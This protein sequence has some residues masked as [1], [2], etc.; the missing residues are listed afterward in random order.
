MPKSK[1]KLPLIFTT[2]RSQVPCELQ[3]LLRQ[4]ASSR[5]VTEGAIDASIL[6]DAHQTVS[7]LLTHLPS[8]GQALSQMRKVLKRQEYSAECVKNA[9]H[10][11]SIR[12]LGDAELYLDDSFAVSRECHLDVEV[13]FDSLFASTDS[14]HVDIQLGP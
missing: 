6:D 2:T 5:V 7:R 13:D 11:S 12:S 8:H 14:S 1:K 10:H 3:S 9:H 4:L